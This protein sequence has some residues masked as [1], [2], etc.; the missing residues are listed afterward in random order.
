MNPNGQN[1]RRIQEILK[2]QRFV[3]IADYENFVVPQNVPIVGV[4]NMENFRYVAR[5]KNLFKKIFQKSLFDGMLILFVSR[6]PQSGNLVR[7]L[8]NSN[9]YYFHFGNI[10][11]AGINIY[12]T[13]F[14]SKLGN[15]TRFLVPPDVITRDENG[16]R[17]RYDNQI[18]K[19]ENMK[20]AD[21]RVQPLVNL[22][23]KY[24]KCYDQEGYIE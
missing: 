1:N 9:N 4:E 3:F 14:Y 17:E 19:F 24:H 11:L 20:V 18:L 22:I 15:R 8:Q 10:D 21:P 13:E 23:K 7:W 12:L 16:S 2:S 5:Q 6:Y